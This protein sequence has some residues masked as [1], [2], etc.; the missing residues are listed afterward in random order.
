M[1]WLSPNSSLDR[2]VL[3]LAGIALAVALIS[4]GSLLK[5]QG[6]GFSGGVRPYL[7]RSMQRLMMWHGMAPRTAALAALTH[8]KH[9][10]AVIGQDDAAW[11]LQLAEQFR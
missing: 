5:T 3:A 9:S 6:V 7:K 1:S 4:G 10:G 8:A 11:A 2:K